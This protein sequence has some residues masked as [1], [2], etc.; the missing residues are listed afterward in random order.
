MWNLNTNLLVRKKAIVAGVCLAQR[1]DVVSRRAID[2]R[3]STNEQE[4]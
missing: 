4:R 3:T 1:P 2:Y